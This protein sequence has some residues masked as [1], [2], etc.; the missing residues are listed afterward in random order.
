[1][2]LRYNSRG[3]GYYNQKEYEKAIADYTE[4]IRLDSKNALYVANRANSR[5]LDGKWDD[6]LA[7][8]SEAIRLEPKK[9]EHYTDR[10]DAY[11]D[12][13]EYD[14]AIADYTEAVQRQEKAVGPDHSSVATN[15][16]NLANLYYAQS[17][18]AQA[19]PLYQRL[20]DS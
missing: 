8:Y 19:E 4:A 2:Q 14:K 20:E 5:R 1:M 17:K 15:L 18:Y 16:N 7:D 9:A 13:K 12:R 11:R 10:G 3:T 6:A